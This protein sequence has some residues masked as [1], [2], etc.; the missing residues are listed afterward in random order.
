MD[1]LRR[2]KGFI[3]N[4]NLRGIVLFLLTYGIG[5]S[6]VSASLGV[7][8]I[9]AGMKKEAVSSLSSF[10]IPL[11]FVAAVLA[12]KAIKPHEEF[13]AWRKIVV[14]S[15]INTAIGY[16][17]VTLNPVIDASNSG[18][19]YF[20]MFL[21]LISST[22]V[23]TF[24]GIALGGFYNRIADEDIGGSSLTTLNSISNLGG[25]LTE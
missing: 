7:K 2:L 23:G 6:T 20:I 19:V 16:F 8:L 17:L 3:T 21:Y 1:V 25:Q 24:R 15:V 9:Q 13:S 12:S 22:F 18:T 11:S 14:L 10:M 4:K 5:L